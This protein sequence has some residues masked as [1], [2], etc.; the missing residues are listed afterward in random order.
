MTQVI[1]RE[2]IE[3]LWAGNVDDDSITVNDLK[4]AVEFYTD[5][6]EKLLLLGEQF[7]LARSFVSYVLERHKEN[8]AAREK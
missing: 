4:L 7:F 3:K 1:T 5:L 2:V 8:L 6:E